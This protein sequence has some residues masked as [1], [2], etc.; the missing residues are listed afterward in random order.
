MSRVRIK[1]CGVVSPEDAC[2]ASDCGAD[3]VGLN[4]YPQSPRYLTPE[5]AAKIVRALPAYTSSVG[6][7][8]G[9][10]LSQACAIAFQ[11]G[12]RAL[13]TYDCDISE[14]DT[15]PFAHVPAFRVKD[16]A[17]LDRVR[18]YVDSA[19]ARGKRPGAV[20]IDSR[21][22]GQV[23]GTGQVAPWSLLAS[24]DL[25]VPLVLAGGLTP[26]NVAEAIQVVRPWG[27]DVASGVELAPGKKDHE[28]V[29]EFIRNVRLASESLRPSRM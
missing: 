22:D 17:D 5:R 1:I 10:R 23:G 3:A 7:V 15:F 13:Q 14:E 16:E 29:A 4:F 18:Q 26:E 27:V 21:V 12:L 9:M 11:L 28:K 6:V 25:G 24:I 2:F 20:L 8:V 19:T